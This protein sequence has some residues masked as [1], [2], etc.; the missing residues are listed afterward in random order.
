LGSII[1]EIEKHPKPYDRQWWADERD[2]DPTS[3]SGP[4]EADELH[5]IEIF[6]DPTM[7]PIIRFR[8]TVSPGSLTDE[9]NTAIGK[10]DGELSLITLFIILQP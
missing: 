7:E 3:W 2:R 10:T 6:S 5:Y 9:G 1:K 4:L 8:G